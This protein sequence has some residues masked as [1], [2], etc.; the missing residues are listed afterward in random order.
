MTLPAQIRLNDRFWKKVNEEASGC[1][2][3]QAHL[4]QGGYGRFRVGNRMV[5]AHRFSYESMVGPVPEGLELDHLCRNRACVNPEHLEPVTRAV[6]QQRSPL[7][8][9]LNRNKTHCKRNHPYDES[10]THTTAAG[11]RA[12]KECDRLKHALARERKAA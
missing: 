9:D 8:G 3:W 11:T 4:N 2:T 5:L 6:N 10:N 12:C 7:L 1:L